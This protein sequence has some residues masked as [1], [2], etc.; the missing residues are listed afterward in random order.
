MNHL[1]LVRCSNFRT[2]TAVEDP[3]VDK[4]SRQQDRTPK[5]PLQADRAR[6]Q[7]HFQTVRQGTLQAHQGYHTLRHRDR[8]I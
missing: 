6:R 2:G 5:V 8:Q 3:P 4:V 1:L 7:V